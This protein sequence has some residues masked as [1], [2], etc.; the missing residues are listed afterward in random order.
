MDHKELKK[1]SPFSWAL[2]I[3]IFQWSIGKTG[4]AID[5]FL[6]SIFLVLSKFKNIHSD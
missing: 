6:N 4:K 2:H 1:M 5:N 3:L